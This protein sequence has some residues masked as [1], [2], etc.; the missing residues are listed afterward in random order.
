[1]T[2]L[3]CTGCGATKDAPTGAPTD[4][5]PSEHCGKCPPW[6]C[7]DCGEICSAA[8]L[9]ACWVLLADLPLADIKALF[10]ADGMFNITPAEGH[11]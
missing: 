4:V 5:Y 10:A 1:M 11:A 7:K 6:T 9:C 3:T 8:A 2:I